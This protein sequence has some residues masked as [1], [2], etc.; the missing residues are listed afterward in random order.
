ME[1]LN[2]PQGQF[3]LNRFPVK[4]KDTLRAW[5]AADE[6]ILK[7]LDNSL[8]ATDGNILIMN[9]S[10]GALSTALAH[11]KPTMLS[12]SYLAEQGLKQNLEQND[13]TPGQVCFINSL[14]TPEKP[15]DLVLIKI[16]KS[17]A[18]LEEQLHRIRPFIRPSTIIIAGAM[19][20]MIHTNTLR[21]FERIIGPTK[22]S[23][24]VKKARLI[25]SDVEEMSLPENP[26]PLTLDLKGEQ[27]TRNHYTLSN[28]ANVFS[29]ESMDIG[30]RFF[31]QTLQQENIASDEALSIIDL[32]CGNGVVGLIAAEHF[33]NAHLHFVDESYMAVDS[34]RINFQRAFPEREACFTATDC[35][36]GLEANSADLILNNPP[37]HQ[38]NV[39]GDF[40]AQQMFRESKKVLKK[41]GALWVV[42]NRHLGYH[43][44][45]KRLMGNCTLVAGNKKFVVLK[46]V[47]R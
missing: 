39:V 2:A 32:G 42:G 21:L 23:L 34:A 47:K 30:S 33:P 11:A 27:F 24:A 22:T 44:A 28:H 19:S 10:F 16:P 26:Y 7:H 1:Q 3:N 20:K 43:T 14:Q 5:D 37:F 25:F 12:D 35:L 6:Y 41:G 15:L 18:M 8:I 31:L 4:P 9:D 38:Q 45:L 36:S 13:I 46:A 40:I 29:R 17:H